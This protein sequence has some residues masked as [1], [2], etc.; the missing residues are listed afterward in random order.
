MVEWLFISPYDKTSEIIS[1]PYFLVT[2]ESEVYYVH[3]NES[4]EIKIEGGN[5]IFPPF[6]SVNSKSVQAFL[7]WALSTGFIKFNSDE[8]T[9]NLA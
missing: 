6:L 5:L 2:P 3:E 4:Y 1:H 7:D 9:T 8:N